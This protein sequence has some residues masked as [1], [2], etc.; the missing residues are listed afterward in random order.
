MVTVQFRNSDGE[1]RTKCISQ[2]TAGIKDRCSKGDLLS[3]VEHGEVVE[4][5]LETDEQVA[6]ESDRNANERRFQTHQGRRQLQ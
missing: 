4:R 1:E 6:L 2:L 5:T 3:I